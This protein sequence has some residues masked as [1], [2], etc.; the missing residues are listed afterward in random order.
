MDSPKQSPNSPSRCRLQ[1]YLAQCGVGSRR[2]CETLISNGRVQVNGKRVE[3]LGT[4]VD[5]DRDTV[6]CDRKAVNPESHVYIALNKPRDVLCTSSDPHGG[7][8]FHQCL[9]D[10]AQRTFVA[11]RLDKDSE[12]LLLVTNDGSLVYHLT[13]PQYHVDKVYRV[14]VEGRLSGAGLRH[15]RQGVLSDG[16]Q[17]TAREVTP[18]KEGQSQSCYRVVLEQGRKRQIRRMF[19]ACGLTVTRLRR[20]AVGSLRL[21]RLR[22]GAWRHLTEPEVRKLKRESGISAS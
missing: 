10:L 22:P 1:R 13:H 6:T 20:D 5:P 16:E 21:G 15:L 18:L 11:G 4:T 7:R 2:T 3:R 14:W 12:G 8:M 17:L 9:G 19:A